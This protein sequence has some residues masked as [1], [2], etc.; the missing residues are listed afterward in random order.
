MKAISLPCCTLTSVFLLVVAIAI[1]PMTDLAQEVL[2]RPDSEFKGD[3]LSYPASTPPHDAVRPG[4]RCSPA[5]TTTA[6][7]RA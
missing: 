5:V 6:L 1:S 7:A 2:P 3:G 4:Q